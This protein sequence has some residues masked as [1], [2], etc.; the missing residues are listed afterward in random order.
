MFQKITKKLKRKKRIEYDRKKPLYRFTDRVMTVCLPTALLLLILVFFKKLDPDVAVM[1]FGSVTAVTVIIMLPFLYNLQKLSEYTKELSSGNINN[2][3]DVGDFDEEEELGQIVAA[4]TKMHSDWQNQSNELQ[5]RSL[6]NA[7]IIDGL[8]D[9]LIIYNEDGVIINANYA[10][11]D[12]FGLPLKGVGVSKIIRKNRLVNDYIK[13]FSDD[14]GCDEDND[15]KRIVFVPSKHVNYSI[16]ER[17]DD[18]QKNEENGDVHDV[19]HS[20]VSNIL[21]MSVTIERLP[22]KIDDKMV[23]VL[24]FHDVTNIK[25]LEKMQSDFVANASHELRTPLSVISGTIETIQGAARNDPE[26]AEKFIK[27]MAEQAYRMEL[28]VEDLLILSRISFNKDEIFTD[29]VDV[30]KQVN[31]VVSAVQSKLKAKNMTISLDSE[32]D[33]A[34]KGSEKELYQVFENIV[35]NAIKYGDS[36]TE[37]T[38][39]VHK[40]DKVPNDPKFRHMKNGAICLSVHNLGEGIKKEEIDRVTERFYRVDTSRNKK[41]VGSGLG[42]AIVEHILSR[43]KGVLDIKSSYGKDV[44]FT[45]FLPIIN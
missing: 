3:P 25:K 40:L 10:A 26:A 11:R 32:T 4:V 21:E 7:A 38:I 16:K 24:V 13:V 36:D 31:E 9:P 44:T 27:L 18:E 33:I 22:G 41:I 15:D 5:N 12:L 37:I 1:S 6:S 17:V 8:P 23:A 34:S 28:L 20:S 29:Y 14:D 35:S 2:I 19:I 43:H 42:L 39:K 30:S 45:I